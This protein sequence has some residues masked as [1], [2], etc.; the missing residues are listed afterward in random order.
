VASLILYAG[1]WSRLK[2]SDFAVRTLD[3]VADDWPIS[4]DDLRPYYD[5]TDVEFG[6]SGLGGDPSFPRRPTRRCRRC[7][8]ARAR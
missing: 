8:S 4:F 6:A 5:Q 2:P 1:D 7:R 3:G